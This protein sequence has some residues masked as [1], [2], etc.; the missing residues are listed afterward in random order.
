MPANV[1]PVSP[2]EPRDF[3]SGLTARLVR[4]FKAQV[5]DWYD[6]CRQLSAWEERHLIEQPTP[7]RLAEHARLLDELEHAGRWLAQATQTPDFP[8]RA[9]AELVSMTVQDLKDR[10]AL[11]HGPMTA[12]QRESVLRDIFHES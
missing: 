5:E 9:T 3:G 7:E 6:V 2:A 4:Y 12:E 10:R 11:W 8:D 1:V